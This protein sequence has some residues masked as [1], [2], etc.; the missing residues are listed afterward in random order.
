M[1]T[2]V[3]DAAATFIEADEFAR[4]TLRAL[5]KGRIEAVIPS[6]MKMPIILNTLFPR[7]MGRMVGRV[8]LAALRKAGVEI[9]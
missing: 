6:H 8:K 7:W 4:R 9:Q 2:W 3:T 1:T 5:A